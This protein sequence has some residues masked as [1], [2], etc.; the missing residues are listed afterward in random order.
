MSR[1]SVGLD[2]WLSLYGARSQWTSPSALKTRHLP[3]YVS[4]LVQFRCF[5]PV[6]PVRLNPRHLVSHNFPYAVQE[7]TFPSPFLST[8]SLLGHGM[9]C[10]P[11]RR[12]HL[13][14][15]RVSCYCHIL[16]VHMSSSGCSYTS[17]SLRAIMSSYFRVA[18]SRA[19]LFGWFV[20]FQLF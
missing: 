16:F 2:P 19:F 18:D 3:K 1:M 11:R 8:H 15:S 13:P 10:E 14:G 12:R 17:A 4:M 6:P 20:G 5:Y 7:S 9:R